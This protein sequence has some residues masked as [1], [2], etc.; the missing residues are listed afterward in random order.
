M[1]GITF[2]DDSVFS[3][4]RDYVGDNKLKTSAFLVSSLGAFFVAST[5][6]SIQLIGF[7]LWILSNIAWIVIGIDEQDYPL[8]MTFMVYFMFNILGTFNR[9]GWF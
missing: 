5:D 2:E 9:W 1:D 6:L 7:E 4:V 3:R 8:M